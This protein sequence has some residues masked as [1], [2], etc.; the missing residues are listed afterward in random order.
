MFAHQNLDELASE[1]NLRVQDVVDRIR[2]LEA[3]GAIT[4]VLDDRG[5]CVLLLAETLLS[6]AC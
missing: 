4:G 3:N 5:A 2:N 1:Y 6:L